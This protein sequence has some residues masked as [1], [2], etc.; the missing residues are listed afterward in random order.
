M[1]RGIAV[2]VA[3]SAM[4]FMQ[5]GV[6]A[7]A[8]ERSGAGSSEAALRGRVVIECDGGERRMHPAAPPHGRCSVSGVITD[9]GK[10]FDDDFLRSNPHGRT[11]FGAK[12]T[13]QMSVYRERRGHWRIIEGTE[14]YAGLR[15]RGRESSTGPCPGPIGPVGCAISFTMTGTVTQSPVSAGASAT[16]AVQGKVRVQLRGYMK[17][18]QFAAFG[19]GRFTMSG[20]ISDRGR[21]VDEFQ[22]GHPPNGPHVRTLR[23]AKGT[24]Q[25]MVDTGV[26]CPPNCVPR[27]PKW[28]ITKG[29]KAYAGLRGRGTQEGEYRFVGIDATMIGRV[30]R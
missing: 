25:M 29:T 4:P 3:L 26:G 8:T 14:A 23:G 28:R 27:S 17:G 7:A 15:G 22:G 11:F 10:F 20:A 13:I 6:T 12:G 2:A 21:F 16:E 9:R 30:W 18:P 19:R 5:V 1:T 24:I